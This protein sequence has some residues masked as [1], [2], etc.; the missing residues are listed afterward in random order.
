[1]KLTFAEVVDAAQ[2]AD[3][4]LH[5]PRTVVIDAAQ[6]ADG[7]VQ[8]F[9]RRDGR[10]ACPVDFHPHFL[11]GHIGRVVVAGSA[12]RDPLLVRLPGELDSAR[13]AQ[14]DV[15]LLDLKF[16]SGDLAR[17]AEHDR[18]PVRID[19]LDAYPSRSENVERF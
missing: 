18:Q 12:D 3:R 6:A 10:L 2:A 17:S 1:M 14:V 13:A 8:F 19:P 16:T 7:K 5:R 4:A 11:R 9:L 15:Q